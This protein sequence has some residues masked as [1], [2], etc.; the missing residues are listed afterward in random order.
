MIMLYHSSL[1]AGH[2]GVIKMYL[3]INDKC[4]IQGLIHYLCSYKK[5]VIFSNYL[6]MK[7]HLQDSCKLELI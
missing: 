5:A 3:T 4:F 6:G 7:S 1:F 2:Q